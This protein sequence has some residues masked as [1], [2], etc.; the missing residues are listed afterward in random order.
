MNLVDIREEILYPKFRVLHRPWSNLATPSP[1]SG[2]AGLTREVGRVERE[3][4]TQ[5]DPAPGP[6]QPAINY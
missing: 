5:V 1:G 4:R 6:N 3:P 2:V